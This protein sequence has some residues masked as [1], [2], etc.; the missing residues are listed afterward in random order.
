[1][2]TVAYLGPEATFSH[3]A[4]VRY[5]GESASFR[6]ADSIEDVFSLVEKD[7]CSWGVVPIE[8]SYE[9]SVNITFDLF[10]KYELN[11]CAEVFVRIR[12]HLLSRVEKIEDI[13][14]VYSHSQAL[15]QCRSWIKTNLPG[16]QSSEVASTS[17]A[18]KIAA[19][20]PESAAL[21]RK[22][23]AMIHGLNILAEGIEDHPDNVTRFFVIGKSRAEPTG[24]DKTSLLFL[25]NHQ[26]GA[27]YASLGHLADR[28]VNMTRIESR[29]M[30]GRN[31]EYMFFLDIEGHQKD[32]NI[33]EALVEMEKRCVFLKIL[34]SYPCG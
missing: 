1:L 14:R 30:K 24:K 2:K 3:Q 6:S 33:A 10:Y 9:G 11:I 21:G 19:D 15:A 7:T 17:F 32:G 26:A 4:A 31:W 27:L 13:K 22:T 23:A 5:Y 25:L 34:G 18:A 29:P 8:N 12:H 16:I 28:G 20:D